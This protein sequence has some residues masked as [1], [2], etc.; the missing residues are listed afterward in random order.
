M[1]HFATYCTIHTCEGLEDSYK[2]RISHIAGFSSVHITSLIAILQC[3]LLNTVQVH[4]E[5]SLSFSLCAQT[6]PT[7]TTI[8]SGKETCSQSFHHPP[9][10]F[11]FLPS[12]LL[13]ILHLVTTARPIHQLNRVIQRGLSPGNRAHAG[14]TACPSQQ[15]QTPNCRK[16][17]QQDA[18]YLSIMHMVSCQIVQHIA[19]SV[20]CVYQKPIMQASL[21]R[22]WKR[23][24]RRNADWIF[25]DIFPKFSSISSHG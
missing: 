11:S 4:L 25:Y 23:G 6:K 1:P 2:Q 5:T 21:D 9:P 8:G 14:C 10:T 7:I 18:K 17:A 19:Y 22:R 20:I 16:I 12:C 3:H 15:A 13:R 24:S